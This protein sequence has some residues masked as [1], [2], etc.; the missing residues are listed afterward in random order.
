ML[1]SVNNAYGDAY[2]CNTL[3]FRR[4]HAQSENKCMEDIPFQEADSRSANEEI[5]RILLKLMAPEI[6]PREP[7]TPTNSLSSILI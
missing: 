5:S 1:L 2:K 3:Y 6:I 4:V 7:R